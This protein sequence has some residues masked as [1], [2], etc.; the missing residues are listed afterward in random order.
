MKYLRDPINTRFL[1]KINAQYDGFTPEALPG[2]M[3]AG[4]LWLGWKRYM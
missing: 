3:R 1:Y 2:R 4:K